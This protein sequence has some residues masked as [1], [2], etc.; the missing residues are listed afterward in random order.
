MKDKRL[1]QDIAAK[2]VALIDEGQYG[3][4]ARLP[5]ERELA[6]RF[7]VSRVTVREAEIALQAQGLIQ[8]K[9]GSGVYVTDVNIPEER[10]LPTATAFDVTQARLL[11]EAETAA[12][13]AAEID[14][15]GLDRLDELVAILEDSDASD[16]EQANQADREFHLTIAQATGNPAIVFVMQ[17]LWSLRDEIEEVKKAHESVCKDDNAARVEEHRVIVEALRANDPAQ[18]RT[19]MRQHFTRLMTSMLEA[20]EQRAL[21]ELKKQVS[22]SRER[23]LRSAKL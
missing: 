8:I 20:S 23:F 5:T 22:Q 6:Q 19:S 4:G 3:P 21:D 16:P 15:A 17:Q 14:D 7:G 18:A 11:F 10:R 2:I 13:A 1:Y 9:T 12:L